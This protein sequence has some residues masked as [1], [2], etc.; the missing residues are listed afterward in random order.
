MHAECSYYFGV[1]GGV[2]LVGGQGG[3][4]NLADN[5]DDNKK[6]RWNQ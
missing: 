2:E 3:Q 5:S 1:G 6:N 4:P